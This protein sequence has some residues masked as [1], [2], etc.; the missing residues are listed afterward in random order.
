MIAINQSERKEFR[1]I[2]NLIIE[3]LDNKETI[4]ALLQA[5]S[6]EEFVSCLVD[7]FRF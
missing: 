2:F 7:S 6:Y 5:D 4:D 3:S 1:K